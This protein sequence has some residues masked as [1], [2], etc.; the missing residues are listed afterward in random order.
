METFAEKPAT[1]RAEASPY[2][3]HIPSL[4]GLRAFAVLG[5]MASHLFPGGSV[6]WAEQVLTFGANGVHL[7]FVLSGFLITGILFDSLGDAHFFRKFYARRTLRIFPLYYAV[8]A[9]FALAGLVYGLHHDGQL[10]SLALY[11]DNTHLIAAPIWRQTGDHLPLGHFWSLAVEEQFYLVWPFVVFMVRKRD[12]LFWLCVA[13]LVLGP[14]FRSIAT[15]HGATYDQINSNTFLRADTLLAGGALALALRSRYHG[16]VLAA[17]KWIT[18]ISGIAVFLFAAVP[19]S[20][21]PAWERTQGLFWLTAITLLSTGIIALAVQPGRLA[22][23]SSWEPLRWIGKYSYGIYVFHV[24]WFGLWGGTVKKFL[25]AN[26]VQHTAAATA[27][28]G[29]FF[30]ILSIVT[31]YLSYELMERRFLRLKR[32]FDYRPHPNTVKS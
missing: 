23:I 31:A 22:A 16:A 8:I 5:V 7:F 13:F 21:S 3:R 24:I 28:T 6:P 18:A 27:T 29:I 2:S 14:L 9:G 10:L 1:T 15:A 32:F 12:R 17:A 25:L 30:G 11:L 26:S 19:G 20:V 4:D